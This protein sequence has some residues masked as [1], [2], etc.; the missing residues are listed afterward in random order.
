MTKQP[1]KTFAKVE[2]H[3]ARSLEGEVVEAGNLSYR[4]IVVRLHNLERAYIK[5]LRGNAFF[6]RELRRRVAEVLLQQAIFHNCSLAVCRG[7]F[8]RLSKIGFTNVETKASQHLFYARGAHERGHSLVARR[9]ASR[10]V[11]ELRNSLQRRKSWAARENLELLKT[12]LDDLDT[13][14]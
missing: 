9:V 11:K 8:N 2:R 3:F 7:R 10:M 4:D 1:K 5:Q 6:V 13:G 14:K 12:L